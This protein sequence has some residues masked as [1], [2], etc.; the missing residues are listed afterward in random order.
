M[1]PEKQIENNYGYDGSFKD[2][3]CLKEY[4][5]YKV[6]LRDTKDGETIEE[7][8]D[9]VNCAYDKYKFESGDKEADYM[10]KA[11]HKSVIADYCDNSTTACNIEDENGNP[12][13]PDSMCIDVNVCDDGM[14]IL[15]IIPLSM[16]FFKIFQVL[17]E[18]LSPD[19][20]EDL[21]K[22]KSSRLSKFKQG[23]AEVK[24]LEMLKIKEKYN[25]IL[26]DEK[27]EYQKTHP[28]CKN[29]DE[30]EDGEADEEG[31][32]VE[33]SEEVERSNNGTANNNNKGATTSEKE[34]PAAV[35]SASS[36]DATASVATNETKGAPASV[37]TNETKGAP[38]SG[39]AA[40]ANDAAAPASGGATEQITEGA[41]ENP[42]P[43]AEEPQQ[44]EGESEANPE[45]EEEGS[46]E[47]NSNEGPKEEKIM[48]DPCDKYNFDLSLDAY[49][50]YLIWKQC[51]DTDGTKKII[52]DYEQIMTSDMSKDPPE[53]YEEK[54]KLI[55]IIAEHVKQGAQVDELTT[56]GFVGKLTKGVKKLSKKAWNAD[57]ILSR[58]NSAAA[59][60]S[61][62]NM[63]KGVASAATSPI[64]GIAKI[65]KTKKNNAANNKSG[66]KNNTKK[67]NKTG[68]NNN[69]TGANTNESAKP[70]N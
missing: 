23:Q 28:E 63:L 67:N 20:I 51:P 4:G 38:A 69:G 50:K 12:V 57:D 19:K 13:E 37:A 35:N 31:E 58:C 53:T 46:E 36:D 16:E 34:T 26:K 21:A 45:S 33:G 70:N 25:E 55:D 68:T 30:E 29:D 15:E 65:S 2:R 8:P 24:M 7:K 59:K 11:A 43:T 1:V 5:D 9:A 56:T 48:A 10:R 3:D 18:D 62:G 52:K 32:E 6:K 42:Q 39:A 49:N 44:A 60:E 66:A 27:E 64:K 47:G 61:V 41:T 22:A 40:T 17:L 54:N 14:S